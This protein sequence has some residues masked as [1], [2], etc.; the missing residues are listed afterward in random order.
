MAIGRKL[1]KRQKPVFV[2]KNHRT[3][4][5]Y[6]CKARRE[7]GISDSFFVVTMDKHNDLFPLSPE[8]K[9]EILALDLNNL[10]KV[11]NFVKNRLKKLND[12][13]IFAF[14]KAFL[15]NLIFC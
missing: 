6:W 7:F 12:D 9:A 10:V 11:K 5:Y 15:R 1:E 13:Y 4:F 8:K 2:F 3:S 14:C